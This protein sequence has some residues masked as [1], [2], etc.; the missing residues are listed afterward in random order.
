MKPMSLWVHQCYQLVN[1]NKNV[2]TSAVV[3]SNCKKFH[4]V[5]YLRIFTAL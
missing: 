1:V 3:R 5:P 4:L 2:C